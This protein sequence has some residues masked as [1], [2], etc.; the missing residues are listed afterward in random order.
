MTTI[1]ELKDLPSQLNEP[2]WFFP[3]SNAF[4][5]MEITD[6][7]WKVIKT[8]LLLLGKLQVVG[9][10]HIQSTAYDFEGDYNI[11]VKA[12]CPDEFKNYDCLYKGFYLNSDEHSFIFYKY[13]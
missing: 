7:H 11:R 13:R 5:V 8:R 12:K 3:A 4:R 2:I 1:L 9:R 6:S 10:T